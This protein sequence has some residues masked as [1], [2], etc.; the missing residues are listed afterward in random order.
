MVPDR[1]EAIE[2]ALTIASKNDT[3][4]IAGRGHEEYMVLKDRKI[5]FKD[6]E[7][8]EEIARRLCRKH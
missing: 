7:V 3:V 5:P 2:M 4:I 8:V 1:R 6:A